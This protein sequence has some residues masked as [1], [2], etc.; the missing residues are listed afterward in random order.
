MRPLKLGIIGAGFIARFQ[1]QAATQIRGMDITGIYSR[2]TGSAQQFAGLCK[3]LGVGECKVFATIAELVAHVD[4][5]AVF[6]PNF[7]RVAIVEEIVDAVKKGA[8]LKGIISEKPLARNLIEA[9]KLLALVDEIAVPTA[10]FE[11]QIY[12]IDACADATVAPTAGTNG[13]DGTHAL[14][15]RAWRSA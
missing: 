9:R 15:G 6:S 4:A 3:K 13:F 10:Y 2:S 7:T 14:F 5:V 11:N 1:A 8:P 12:E